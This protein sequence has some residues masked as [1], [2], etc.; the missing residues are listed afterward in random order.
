[1]AAELPPPTAATAND[2]E[3]PTPQRREADWT[4]VQLTGRLAESVIAGAPVATWT[5][6]WVALNQHGEIYLAGA[7]ADCWESARY[8]ATRQPPRG[9]AYGEAGIGS[10]RPLAGHE[11]APDGR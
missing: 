2:P 7:W 6:Q 11:D 8:W 5:G 9:A 4:L 10:R 3:R 1:M